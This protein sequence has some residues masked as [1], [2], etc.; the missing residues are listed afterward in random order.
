MGQKILFLDADGST[1][2]SE[3]EILEEYIK[4]ET[5]PV[6]VC[7]SRMVTSNNTSL[8]NRHV[9]KSLI[10]RILSAGFSMALRMVVS[11]P[12]VL[13]SQCGFK[14]LSRP[15]AQ[16]IIPK[17]RV[18]GWAFDVE[19]LYL[20]QLSGVKVIEVPVSWTEKTGSKLSLVR[21]S[22]IMAFDVLCMG[23]LH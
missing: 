17:C 22:A 13:D 16:I 4:D 8:L 5:E 3:L 1:P 19:L 7:G 15:A 10:R 23:L 6:I 11:C 18:R 21:D 12:T 9:T 20:G 2:I 14:L